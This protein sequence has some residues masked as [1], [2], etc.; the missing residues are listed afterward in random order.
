MNFAYRKKGLGEEEDFNELNNATY[1]LVET[2]PR[3][4]R[5]MSLNIHTNE[6]IDS[7]DISNRNTSK[8]LLVDDEEYNRIALKIILKYH[9]KLDVDSICDEAGNGKEALLAV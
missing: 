1:D 4:I 2:L 7:S 6:Q 8:I 5:H 9:M 3:T